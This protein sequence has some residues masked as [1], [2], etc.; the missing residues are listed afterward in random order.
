MLATEYE[1]PDKTLSDKLTAMV[2]RLFEHWSLTYNE[3]GSV[4]L[5]CLKLLSSI[6]KEHV[7]PKP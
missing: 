3:Q 4:F 1:I 5:L 7:S 6:Q 2:M